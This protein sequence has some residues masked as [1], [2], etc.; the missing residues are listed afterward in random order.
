MNKKVINGIVIAL[1]IILIG[2]VILFSVL[3]NIVLN[4]VI[5]IGGF[6]IPIFAIVITMI[7][8]IKKEKD[9]QEKSKIRNFWL[10]ILFIIYCLLLI[11]VLFL[12]NEYRMGGFE[13]ISTFSKEHFETSNIIPF[14]TIIGYISGTISND[15]NT[16]ST[17]PTTLD[18]S[19]DTSSPTPSPSTFTP[20]YVT[21]DDDFEF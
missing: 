20:S 2:F 13:N 5:T 8:E 15:I 12:N 19:L 11:T 3:P 21:I 1:S 4:V 10:K 9:I 17:N 18:S 6:L 14:S 16:N 7:V